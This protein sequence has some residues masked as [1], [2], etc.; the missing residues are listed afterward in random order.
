MIVKLFLSALTVALAL[1]YAVCFLEIFGVIRF[2]TKK[3][4]VSFPKMLIPF[5]Y[6]FK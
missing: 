5:Y 1:Y 3:Q 6:F 2:T 4:H